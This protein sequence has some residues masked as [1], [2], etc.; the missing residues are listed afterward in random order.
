MP[1]FYADMQA[2]ASE[3]L[4]EFNQGVMTYIPLVGGTNDWD[5]KTD[6]TP[7]TLAGTAR[8]VQTKYL[9]DLITQT[10]LQ[11]TAAVFGTVPT[12]AGVV[13]IDGVRRQVI[14]VEQIPAAGTVVA[15]R[16]FVK[17]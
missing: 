1:D 9:T 15:W 13:T 16:L 7:V 12:N 17:G 4:A 6:G 2:V 11:I 3:M 14:M 8:G 5:P 10:D